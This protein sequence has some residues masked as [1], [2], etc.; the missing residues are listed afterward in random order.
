MPTLQS[1]TR[2][3]LD[4]YVQGAISQYHTL[5]VTALSADKGGVQ[6]G[7]RSVRGLLASFSDATADVSMLVV[8]KE[9]AA[10]Q[11]SLVKLAKA[12]GINAITPLS[13]SPK[14]NTEVVGPIV[15]PAP[16]TSSSSSSSN[17]ALI[18]GVVGGVSGAALLGAGVVVLARKQKQDVAMVSAV[19][20]VNVADLKSS[21]KTR[22]SG[23]AYPVLLAG[24]N[25]G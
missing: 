12:P 11:I 17:A 15:T 24:N 13:V 14:V 8:F 23:T 9:G 10:A 18:G 7:R 16:Q 22:S 20:T 2:A 5:Q 19:Q 6:C 1:A 21:F 3:T 25:A 4:D